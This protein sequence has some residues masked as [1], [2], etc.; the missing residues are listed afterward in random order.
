MHSSQ[1]FSIGIR[2]TLAIEGLFIS[3]FLEFVK[4]PAMSSFNCFIL[5]C[6][7]ILKWSFCFVVNSQKICS[8]CS[9]LDPKPFDVFESVAKWVFEENRMNLSALSVY[10]L[11]VQA[12]YK[13]LLFEYRS[14]SHKIFAI[15]VPFASSGNKLC[16]TL[17]SLLFRSESVLTSGTLHR[18]LADSLIFLPFPMSVVFCPQYCWLIYLFLCRAEQTWMENVL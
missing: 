13:A 18:V 6:C 10:L 11:H 16:L 8:V 15:P 2:A 7:V 3:L 17:Q 14:F 9:K 12:E 5:Y 1:R 4:P